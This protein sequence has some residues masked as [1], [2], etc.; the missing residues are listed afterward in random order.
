MSKSEAAVHFAAQLVEYVVL[1]ADKLKYEN[2]VKG[3]RAVAQAWGHGTNG[4]EEA[5][6]ILNLVKEEA[7]NYSLTATRAWIL[8]KSVLH[9][10]K[11]LT[12]ELISFMENL[13]NNGI[14][15][16][17]LFIEKHEPDRRLIAGKT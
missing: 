17:T 2:I 9:Y 7:F 13:E 15:H 3:L 4:Y 12:R 16:Y 5:V 1:N 8:V 10:G 14:M 11:H 6:A